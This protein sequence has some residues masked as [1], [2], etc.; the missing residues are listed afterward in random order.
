M[1]INQNKCTGLKKI[2]I[3]GQIREKCKVKKKKSLCFFF[4]YFIFSIYLMQDNKALY[5]Q[6]QY[7][8]ALL[9]ANCGVSLE[10]IWTSVNF[11]RV[12][13]NVI[14]CVLDQLESLS[15]VYFRH[16]CYEMG[17]KCLEKLSSSASSPLSPSSLLSSSSLLLTLYLVTINIF[18]SGIYVYVSA[19]GSYRLA[20]Q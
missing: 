9:P 5:T 3:Q 2:Y 16:Y 14:E 6:C 11:Q 13:F 10:I 15:A 1:K 8:P 18:N 19:S 20:T 17:I 4:C 7:H 12:A